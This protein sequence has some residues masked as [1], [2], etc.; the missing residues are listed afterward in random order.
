MKDYGKI[1][2]MNTRQKG[3]YRDKLIVETIDNFECLTT[4]QIY[5]LFFTDIRYGIVKCRERLR[6]LRKRDKINSHRIDI[7]ECSYHFIDKKPYYLQHNINRNW[8]FMYI[9]NMVRCNYQYLKFNELRLEY[10]MKCGIRTDGIIGFKNYV[11]GEFRYWIIESD[12]VDSRNRFDKIKNYND[13]YG[14]RGEGYKDEYWFD[15]VER[16]PHILIVSDSNKKKD[17]ILDRV[18]EDNIKVL[19]FDVITID[20]IRKKLG[21]I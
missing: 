16:F 15:R 9:M 8:G 10:Y 1:K 20:E 4:E 14:D 19:K 13:K 3:Y 21:L 18:I 7:N 2:Y 6:I 17:K 5:Y 11:T 12:K